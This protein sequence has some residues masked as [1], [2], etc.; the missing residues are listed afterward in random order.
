ML[1]WLALVLLSVLL[2]HGGHSALPRWLDP[3]RLLHRLPVFSA[4]AKPFKYFNVFV[5]MG[6]CVGTGHFL[7][8]LAAWKGRWRGALL[9]A[10]LAVPA[11][12]VPFAWHIRLNWHLFDYPVKGPPVM[13]LPEFYQL[14]AFD[15]REKKQRFRMFLDYFFVREGVGILNWYDPME[16]PCH[17]VPR[18]RIERTGM[19]EYR[20]TENLPAWRG[21]VFLAGGAGRAGIRPGT[22]S[23]LGFTVDLAG[24]KEGALLVVNQ[25][26]DRRWHS[27]AGEVVRASDGR[28]AVRLPAGAAEVRL[29]YRPVDHY[30]AL[31]VSVLAFV[32]CGAALLIARRRRMRNPSST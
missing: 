15:P 21:E 32:G 23:P 8:R 22:W 6:V 11:V 12:G 26:Y 16:L 29:R 24:V 2:M 13:K 5:L 10:V 1:G 17:A 27:S 4:M 25:N 30:L 28:L 31:A 18:F 19:E 14:E 9:A 7:D 3:F 20:I